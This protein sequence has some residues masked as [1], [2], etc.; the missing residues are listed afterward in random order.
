MFTIQLILNC[1]EDLDLVQTRKERALSSYRSYN[2]VL[3]HLSN[4]D[5]LA[6]LNLHKNKDIVLQKSGEGNSVVLA[7]KTDYLD[8]IE[9][10]L[11]TQVNLKKII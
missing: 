2:R 10:F 1:S 4:K 11:M 6:L 7:D 3:Q 5:F 9:N 8:Q